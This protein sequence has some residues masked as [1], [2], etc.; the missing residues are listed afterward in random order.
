MHIDNK[1]D[2]DC[3]IIGS[4]PA[5]MSAGIY[6]KRSN[7]NIVIIEKS[8]PGGKVVTTSDV[9]NYPGYK[10]ISG[11]DLSYKMYEQCNELKI[12]FKFDE[13]VNIVKEE[14]IIHI[15]LSSGE[16]IK[17]YSLII[18][19]GMINRK[20][21]IENEDKFLNKGISYCAICDGVLFKNKKIVVIGSGRTAI[22]ETIMLSNI[23][24]EIV[25][26]SNK[27]KF[28]A[29]EISVDKLKKIKNVKILMNTNT[30]RFIGDK[31]IEFVEIE[32]QETKTKDKIDIEGAFIFIG[33]LPISPKNNFNEI[34]SESGFIKVNNKME[35]CVLGV[36]AAGDIIEKEYRQITTAVNDGTIAALSVV[37]YLEKFL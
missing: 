5:G 18:S 1:I 37:K 22:D 19:T 8:T 21:N 36:Y 17:T 34:Y 7:K 13:V 35:T 2:F 10:Y 6:L 32:N 29:E 15:F 33:F 24:K 23:A 9:E 11:P 31:K 12:P 4:G 20:L 30:L 25:L 28:K 14:K 16:V 3:V 27:S 26:I